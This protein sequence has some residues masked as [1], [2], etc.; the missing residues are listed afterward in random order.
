[1]DIVALQKWAYIPDLPDDIGPIRT[2]LHEYS[3]IPA[4]D[5]DHHILRAV[6][7]DD[8][9]LLNLFPVS[10]KGRLTRLVADTPP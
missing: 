4:A 2:F 8:P 3:K 5:I 9:I 1:M 7:S 6:C 10:P